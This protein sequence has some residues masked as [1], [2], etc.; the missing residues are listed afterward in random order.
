MDQ[1]D[2]PSWWLRRISKEYYCALQQ[3]LVLKV[4]QIA[5]IFGPEGGLHL[6]E[7]EFE[8]EGVSL[9][10]TWSKDFRAETAP[11][12][13]PFALSVLVELE[14]KRKKMEQKHRSEFPEKELWDYQPYTQDRE[15]S[16][17][18]EKRERISNQFKLDY[19]GNLHTFEDSLRRPLRN[20][21]NK[22][23]QMS[24]IGNYALCPQINGLYSNEDT[25]LILPRLGWNFET[26]AE[27]A[28]DLFDLLPGG[29][30]RGVSDRLGKFVH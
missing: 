29:C 24:H 20:S 7:I 10:R 23:I 2:S 4:S 26:D 27:V 22:F 12:L 19:K 28:F 6:H 13:R 15:I 3:S 11:A 9:S 1:F 14:N 8:A 30:R 5:F 21:N 18:I 17:A 25:L 16:C